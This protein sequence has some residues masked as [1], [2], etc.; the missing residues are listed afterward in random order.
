ME[1]IICGVGLYERHTNM[2]DDKDIFYLRCGSGIDFF[3]VDASI[4]E[5]GEV[6]IDVVESGDAVGVGGSTDQVGALDEFEAGFFEFEPRGVEGAG[7]VGDEDDAIEAVDFD[8]EFEFVGDTDFFEV[9][10]GV[11]GEAAGAAGEG[12]AVVAG[13]VEVVL[14]EV[15]KVFAQAAIG[16]VNGG[17]ADA[18]VVVFE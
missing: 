10:L 15:V 18:G 9:G 6:G 4:D 11:T 12:D 7:L 8:E 2:I 1:K 3:E 17:G 5:A 16:A 14:Q 13:E